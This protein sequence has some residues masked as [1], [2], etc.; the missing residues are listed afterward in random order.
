MDIMA[1]IADKTA[2]HQDAS[3]DD[4]IIQGILT[5]KTM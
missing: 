4:A 1:Y 3:L 2:N 5:E